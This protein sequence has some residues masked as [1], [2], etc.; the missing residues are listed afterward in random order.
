MF[1]AESLG[2]SARAQQW[3]LLPRNPNRSWN[4]LPPM[5]CSL[6][7]WVCFCLFFYLL[8]NAWWCKYIHLSAL[9]KSE[10]NWVGSD[11]LSLS[12]WFGPVAMQYNPACD[13]S[14]ETMGCWRTIFLLEAALPVS[15]SKCS[16]RP[17]LVCSNCSWDAWGVSVGPA[18]V[19]L[20]HVEVVEHLLWLT[21]WKQ[22]F[23]VFDDAFVWFLWLPSNIWMLK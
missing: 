21:P 20:V 7:I 1:K 16:S 3:C 2:E 12:I 22:S 17:L 10:L 19:P 9:P 23:N 11:S 18:F 13:F 8:Y 14:G 6:S 4:Y 15:F 5:S